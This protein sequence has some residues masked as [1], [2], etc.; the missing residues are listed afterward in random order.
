MISMEKI[1]ANW[2]KDSQIDQ[3]DLEYDSS[4]QLDLHQ[5]YHKALNEARRELRMREAA[6]KRMIPLKQDY[7]SNTLPPQELKKYG[8]EPNRR[9]ILKSDLNQV[10]ESDEDIIQANL[11][12]GEMHDLVVYLESI[13]RAINQKPFIVKNML[14]TRKIN[15]GIN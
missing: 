13:I 12:I 5:K 3:T 4:K 10:L 9:A 15:Y 14:E 11:D 7:Y 2:A 6:K 8:W 1:E